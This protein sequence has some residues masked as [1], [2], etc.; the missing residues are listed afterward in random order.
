MVESEWNQDSY[1]LSTRLYFFLENIVGLKNGSWG[2]EKQW[3]LC[4]YGVE[5][6]MHSSWA[7]ECVQETC[8][9][10]NLKTT[11]SLNNFIYSYYYSQDGKDVTFV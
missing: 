2:R 1:N 5:E 4:C 8:Y 6:R 7:K 3:F 10:Q 11:I 9:G